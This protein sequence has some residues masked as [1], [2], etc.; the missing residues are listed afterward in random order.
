MV[1]HSGS[2]N[3]N[4]PLSHHNYCDTTSARNPFHIVQ[5]ILMF[6]ELKESREDVNIGIGRITWV[7]LMI[8]RRFKLFGMASLGY[9][10]QQGVHVLLF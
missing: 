5:L 7:Y 6:R 9:K 3:M 1:F 10:F 8:T 4:H 2:S